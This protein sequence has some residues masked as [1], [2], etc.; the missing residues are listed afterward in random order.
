M[1]PFILNINFNPE[2]NFSA[3]MLHLKTSQQWLLWVLFSGIWH[4]VHWKKFI[5][6][7]EEHIAS[8]FTVGTCWLLP[9][10]CWLL[11]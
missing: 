1:F 2:I 11:S 3:I 10:S 7:S 8:I 9:D 5:N 4:C 6:T